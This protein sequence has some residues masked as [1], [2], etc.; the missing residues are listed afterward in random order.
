MYNIQQGFM[1]YFDDFKHNH[2]NKCFI[3]SEFLQTPPIHQFT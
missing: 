3:Y 2:K 1:T